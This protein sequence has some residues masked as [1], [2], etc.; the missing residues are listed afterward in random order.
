MVKLII[1]YQQV[2]CK[3]Q[4]Q[5]PICLLYG[6][7]R[8]LIEEK[9]KSLIGNDINEIDVNVYDMTESPIEL[10]LEDAETL[11]FLSDNRIVIIKNPYFL[12]SEKKLASQ[13]VVEHNL[14]KL[15]Q[16]LENPSP[17]ALVIFE[18]PYDKLD[19]RKKIVQ[20]LKK[21]AQVFEA[22]TLQDKDVH[23]WIQNESRKLKIEMDE[24]AIK[25]L[26]SLVGKDL[27]KLKNELEKLSLFVGESGRVTEETLDL[28]VSR[29]L[30]DNIFVLVDHVVNKRMNE[31]FHTLRDLFEQ[32]EE[33]IK[34]VALLARQFRIIAQVHTL[35]K[36]GYTTKQMAAYLKLHP[37][38][39]QKTLQQANQFS[40]TECHRMIQNLAEADYFMKTGKYDKQILLEI[41]LTKIA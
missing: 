3:V 13:S 20:L 4:K 10:A 25:H 15:E 28:L 12:T 8:F 21:T 23:D 1:R 33:P 31:A 5:K 32:K 7:E 41:F 38:V 30:E 11:P 24:H 26:Y 16:Y 17:Y 18:A 36:K 2:V 14:K 40:Q 9:R 37:F 6:N 29:S 19:E 22:N 35:R 39:V 34:I 27:K